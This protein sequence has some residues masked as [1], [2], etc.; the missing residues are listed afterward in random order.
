MLLLV[1]V[2][3][4]GLQY[5]PLS[6]KIERGV[7]QGDA[8]SCAIFIIC[9]D[10]LLRNLNNNRRVKEVKLLR[11]NATNEEINYK[12]AAYADD[13]SVIC[14]KSNDCIQQVFYEYERLVKRSGL[15]LNADKTEILNLSSKGKDKIS[16]RYNDKSF[17]INT[18]GKI[19]FV[20]C[21]IALI[22]MKNI[23]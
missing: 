9:I 20:V 15:E 4:S 22:Q 2:E 8:L 16:F 12:G 13:I 19:K 5:F 21:I 17:A 7:K 14:K 11:K 10:P 1:F 18:I 23:N 6:I 3:V